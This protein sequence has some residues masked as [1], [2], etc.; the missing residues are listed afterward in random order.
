VAGAAAGSALSAQPPRTSVW[1]AGY[2]AWLRS[3][4]GRATAVH[5]IWRSRRAPGPT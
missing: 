5:A 3:A 2:G 4:A 1:R